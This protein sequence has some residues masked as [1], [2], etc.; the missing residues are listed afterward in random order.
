MINVLHAAFDTG[1]DQTPGRIR[2]E[3]V[4]ID[5]GGCFKLPREMARSETAG[6]IV[7]LFPGARRRYWRAKQTFFLPAK[8][9]GLFSPY[10]MVA[11]AFV[12]VQPGCQAGHGQDAALAFDWHV[13]PV[14][15]FR[16]GVLL[17][18]PDDVP[19]PLTE[20]IRYIRRHGR[21]DRR[22]LVR[23]VSLGN[24]DPAQFSSELRLKICPEFVNA[25]SQP[26]RVKRPHMPLFRDHDIE[27]GVMDMGMG[28]AACWRVDQIGLARPRVPRLNR[29][30]R[31]VM[32]E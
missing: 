26:L 20:E 27:Q 7:S 16:R 12:L 24:A 21:D 18:R 32:P 5:H 9:P 11:R 10:L 3:L 1:A 30:A 31:G 25:R 23:V 4:V 17:G 8:T 28:I 13:R 19:S 14:R 22:L 29:R 2:S 6:N 15:S